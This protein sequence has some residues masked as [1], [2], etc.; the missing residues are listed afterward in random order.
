MNLALNNQ[1]KFIYHK[2]FLN[3]QPI[4]LKYFQ[5]KSY[6]AVEYTNCLSAEE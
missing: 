2:T 3:N 1:E 4:N 5:A 6:G